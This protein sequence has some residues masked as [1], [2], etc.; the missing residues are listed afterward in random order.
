VSARLAGRSW[1]KDDH[2]YSNGVAIGNAVSRELEPVWPFL[3]LLEGK[4][5]ERQGDFR[6]TVE[7]K[8][9]FVMLP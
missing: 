7:K 8:L 1:T 2:S 4:D 6:F 5:K 9:S 3:L